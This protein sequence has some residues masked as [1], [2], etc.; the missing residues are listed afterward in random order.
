MKCCIFFLFKQTTSLEQVDE[1]Q[2][3]NVY[4]MSKCIKQLWLGTLDYLYLYYR[5]RENLHFT[6]KRNVLQIHTHIYEINTSHLVFGKKNCTNK[7]IKV[8][9]IPSDTNYRKQGKKIP[10]QLCLRSVHLPFAFRNVTLNHTQ[11]E[12]RRIR[13][14]H[15]RISLLN[16]KKHY[17]GSLKHFFFGK[18][19]FTVS[20]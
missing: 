14:T 2:Y 9:H 18:V 3:G 4:S 11:R 13:D 8:L 19:Q 12:A 5:R 15:T 1:H 16:W 6:W 10:T 17:N 20:N 7:Q